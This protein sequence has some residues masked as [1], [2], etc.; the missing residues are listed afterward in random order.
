MKRIHNSGGILLLSAA[1]AGMAGCGGDDGLTVP[2]TTGAVEVI[3]TT[4]G[5]EPDADAAPAAGP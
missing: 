4:T 5:A 3:A 2:P 1:L